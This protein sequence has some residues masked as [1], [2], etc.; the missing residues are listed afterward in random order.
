MKSLPCRTSCGKW[1]RRHSL[2]RWH[3]IVVICPAPLVGLLVTIVTPG[4][5]HTHTRNHGVIEN[6]QVTIIDTGVLGMAERRRSNRHGDKRK[7]PDLQCHGFSRMASSWAKFRRTHVRTGVGLGLS[8]TSRST[9][10]RRSQNC[11]DPLNTDQ[12]ADQDGFNSRLNFGMNRILSSDKGKLYWNSA[13][14]TSV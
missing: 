11:N 7:V 9:D 8:S 14:A 5:P 6:L 2:S 13:V 12:N 1:P 10:R 4:T 3:C